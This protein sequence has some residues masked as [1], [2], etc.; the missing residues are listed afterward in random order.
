MSRLL[1]EI[2]T[3]AIPAGYVPPALKDLAAWQGKDGAWPV[4]GWI[5]QHDQPPA[6]A[7]AFGSLVFS[8]ADG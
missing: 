8:I 1:L 4:R 5:A 7:T 2:G 3:E 6:Y